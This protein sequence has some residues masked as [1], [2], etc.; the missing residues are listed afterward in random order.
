MDDTVAFAK[1]NGHV[2]TLFGRKINTPE[3]NAKGPGAGFA[4]RAAI[5]A[6]IQGTAADVIRRAMVRMPAAIA[7]LPAR[8]LL[9]VH[10]ELLFE[11]DAG[12]AADLTAVAREVMEGAADP[13][14]KLSVR[15]T[16][17]AGQGANWAEAH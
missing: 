17:D 12:A 6:P 2:A 7:G 1:A 8:M 15:L 10:D 11:V 14:V 5:N 3:I 16:V 13:A 9:Q 4:R